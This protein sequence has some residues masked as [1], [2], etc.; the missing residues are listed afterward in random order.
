MKKKQLNQFICTNCRSNNVQQKKWVDINTNIPEISFDFDIEELWCNDC[1]GHHSLEIVMLPC[2]NGK[3]RIEGY[4]VVNKDN[5]THPE[6]E[7]SFCLYSLSQVHEMMANDDSS[8]WKLLTIYKG[9]VEKPTKMFEGNN[10]R[11]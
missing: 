7:A 11:I 5:E 10:P 2:S 8:Q 1:E 3:P 9:D 6:V 4:Q